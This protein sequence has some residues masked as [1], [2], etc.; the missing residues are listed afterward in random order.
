MIRLEVLGAHTQLLSTLCAK[1]PQGPA[2]C[3]KAPPEM[4]W[5][6]VGR[7]IAG[8][9]RDFVLARIAKKELIPTKRGLELRR[10]KRR[11]APT[12]P[13]ERKCV[14]HGPGGC[15]ID[16]AMRPATC[17]YFLCE[18]TFI[19]GGERKG[20]RSAVLARQAHGAL[21]A[22]FERWDAEFSERIAARWPEGPAWDAAFLDWLGEVFVELEEASGTALS[23]L[24]VPA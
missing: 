1:C 21:R 4:D 17:N 14:F 12:H 5:S 24:P 22:V 10:V 13:M 16:A 18:D 20:E 11:E 15:T 3:C 23:A 7:V 6:D 2:G 9:G 19:E 8:G